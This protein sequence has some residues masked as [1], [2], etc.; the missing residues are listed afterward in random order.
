M[1]Y[2]LQQYAFLCINDN[3]EIPVAN[4]NTPMHQ[5]TIFNSMIFLF[6]F[7]YSSDGKFYIKIRHVLIRN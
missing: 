2:F 6:Y 1:I 5:W 7:V 4:N 3:L